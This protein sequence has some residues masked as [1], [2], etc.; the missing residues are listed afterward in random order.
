VQ[1]GGLLDQRR[2]LLAE[3]EPGDLIGV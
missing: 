2:G 1:A 3:L